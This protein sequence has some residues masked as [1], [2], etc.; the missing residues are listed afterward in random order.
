MKCKQCDSITINGVYCHER[1]CYTA[2]QEKLAEQIEESFWEES[3]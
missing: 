3:I 1:G 2:Y